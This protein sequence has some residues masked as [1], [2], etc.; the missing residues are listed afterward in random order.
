MPCLPVAVDTGAFGGGDIG[1][2]DSGGAGPG[3]AKTGGEGS[4]GAEIRG[5][6]SGGADSGGAASPSGVGAVGRG[7]ASVGRTTGGAGSAGAA[8]T[9]GAGATG[10]G[11]AGVG[12]TGGTGG[13]RGAGLGGARTRAA[14]AGGAAGAAGAGG[15]GGAT[16]GARSAGA[17][18]TEGAGAA[19]ARGAAG[20]GGTGA[21]G[22]GG[23]R[24]AG[25]GG[26]RTRGA[27][28]VG[29][30][31]AAG[32]RGAGGATGGAGGA[33]AASTGGVGVSG[34]GVCFLYDSAQE[35]QEEE[36]RKKAD[37]LQFAVTTTRP[38]IAFACSNLGSG[39]TVRSDQHW[40]KVDH[41]L[42]YLANTRDTALEFGDG[43]ESLKLVG[44][45][46]AD[47]ASDKQNRPSTGGYVFVFGGAAVSWS[48][49]RIKCTTL[50]STESNYVA[51][52]NAGKEG[53][54]LRFVLA[55]LRQL[56]AGTPTVLRVDNK[57]A[58]TVAKGMGLTSNLTHMERRQAWLQHIVK[59]R[60]FSL[61]YILTAEQPADFLTKALH[62][63]A[64]NRCCVAIGQVRLVNVGDGD[65]DVQQ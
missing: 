20:A 63:P 56:D 46:D 53:R 39:L 24:A 65:N 47:D 40:R 4:R 59:H 34:A 31:S 44:Y 35:C 7:A 5:E 62:Y 37:S 32:T 52:T 29:A 12:G 21:G 27:R 57:S 19:G 28:A 51:T 3:G 23:A 2:E 41:C 25:L 6:G 15:A 18:G 61:R 60:K 54:C 13:A 55:K 64:L 14:G 17:A 38:D 8:A 10:A 48:S 49:Q 26:A 30:G 42:A 36:Y 1:G 43:S 45:V 22:T 58:I 11:G 16:G 33:G 50:S 9:G